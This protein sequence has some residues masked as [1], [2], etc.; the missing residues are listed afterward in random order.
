MASFAVYCRRSASVRSVGNVWLGSVSR[1]AFC[2]DGLPD[3]L[4]ELNFNGSKWSAVL[5][6][7]FNQAKRCVMSLKNEFE[8][9]LGNLEAV[10]EELRLKLHLASMEAK[11][12]FEEAE[13][14]WQLIKSKASE[15]ADDSVE[16]SEEYIAKAKIVGEE[17]KEAYQRVAKR[18]S[19]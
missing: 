15:I 18:L 6:T 2:A 11:D 8:S 1:A 7:A 9:L 16:T 3:R 10:R 14:Q 19:E 12:E 17:L 4:L 13:K 5:L